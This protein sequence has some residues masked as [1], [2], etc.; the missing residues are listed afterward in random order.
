MPVEE[1]SGGNQQR[2]LL[3]QLMESP[4]LLLL[5]NPSRGLDVGSA[6]WAWQQ[7]LAYVR[8][9][10]ALVFSSAEIDEILSV[11]DRVLV[12]F[13]G[14]VIVDVPSAS[15]DVQRL[16]QAMAGVA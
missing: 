16:G 4:R 11:A 15:V 8:A 7:L 2:L 1:L 10:A 9:G 14:R 5:E 13:N 6:H 3:S 12:F